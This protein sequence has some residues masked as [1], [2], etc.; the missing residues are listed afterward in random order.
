MTAIRVAVAKLTTESN[1]S[2]A[3]FAFGVKAE[4]CLERGII[5]RIAA[6]TGTSKHTPM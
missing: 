1:V 3:A 2:E 6:L 5:G 4:P